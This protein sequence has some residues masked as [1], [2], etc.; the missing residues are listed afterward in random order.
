MCQ[1]IGKLSSDHRSRKGQFSFKFQRR[2]VPKN[3]Q[4]VMCVCVLAP[5]SVEFSRQEWILEWVAIP[6]SR[7][8]SQP[9]DWTLMA[10][11]SSI[12]AWRIPWTEE[13]HGLQSVGS[14]RVSHDWMASLSLPHCGQILYHLSH[15]ESP[16]TAIQLHLFHMPGKLCSN[17]SS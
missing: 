9:R 14:Q 12:L 8:S 13:P 3:V 15:Q 11:H 10:T 7:V 2:A 17:L 4:T 5:L 16:L 6:L 1:Q